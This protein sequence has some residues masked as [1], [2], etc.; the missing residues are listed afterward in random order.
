MELDEAVAEL[1]EAV[2]EHLLFKDSFHVRLAL[3]VMGLMCDG[4]YRVMQN[5]LRE[6][7]DNIHTID[8]VGGVAS[9]LQHF[10]QDINEETVELVHLMLQTLI[11]MCVGNYSNQCLQKFYLELRKHRQSPDSTPITTRQLESLIRLTEV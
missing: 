2:V 6:Q 1:D 8:L 4:Q 3:Q 5:Y 11:E 9:F 10:Y 7:R